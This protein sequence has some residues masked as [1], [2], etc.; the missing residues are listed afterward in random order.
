MTSEFHD[1]NMSFPE[2]F[3]YFVE[4]ENFWNSCSY[5]KQL[6][7]FGAY[8]LSPWGSYFHYCNIHNDYE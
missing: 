8:I 3:Q 5:S 2:M 7:Q 4:L 1:L 6:R